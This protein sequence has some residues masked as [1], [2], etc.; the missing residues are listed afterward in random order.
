M[1]TTQV[2]QDNVAQVRRG[3]DAFG[4]GDMPAL[5]ELYAPNA[6]WHGPTMGV[7]AGDSIGRD[8]IFKTFEQLARETS[9]TFRASPSA[10]AAAGDRVFVQLIATGQRKG[11]SLD[12]NDVLVFTVTDGKVTNVRLYVSDVQGNLDFWS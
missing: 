6:T 11:K 5:A 8:A 7:I 4:A 3:F 12:S 10:F 9:G 2:E 1:A